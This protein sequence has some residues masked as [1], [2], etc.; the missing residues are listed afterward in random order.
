MICGLVNRNFGL[1]NEYILP[2]V[3]VL[4]WGL[5]YLKVT[6]FENEL[7]FCDWLHEDD[8]LV[9]DSVWF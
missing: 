8:S 2:S 7:I 9:C 1:H 5:V 3:S 4:L 6:Y